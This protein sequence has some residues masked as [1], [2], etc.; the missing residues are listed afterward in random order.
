MSAYSIDVNLST[1]ETEI[2]DRSMQV[3]VVVDFWAPWCAPCRTL[4]PVLEKLAA[5]HAGR[6]V[7]AKVN[8][9]DNPQLAAQFGVRGIPAVK[10]IV[11][12]EMVDEF[13]GALPPAQVRAFVER[14]LPSPAEPL[15]GRAAQA[16]ADGDS[17]AAHALLTEAI[18]LDP[19]NEAARLDLIE[20]LINVD[21][22]ED[23]E[24]ML[25]ALADHAQDGARV[26]ALR[27]RLRLAASGLAAD[28]EADYAARLEADP[29]DLDLRMK[30]AEIC[31]L[32][33]DYAAAFEQLLAVVSADRS[34]RDDGARRTMVELFNLLGSDH[35]AV[36]EYRRRLAA[37]LNR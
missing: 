21:D 8:S 6:F 13:T 30:L 22:R 15:R 23:A 27:L 11:G 34:F 26:D 32:K 35:D 9:D 17:A 12:G 3:P 16:H 19:N 10:M 7:L 37:L 20:L 28:Q 14:W 1:F 4:K 5:E 31:V 25:D 18:A 24:K 36:R 33:Q 29:D 2:L